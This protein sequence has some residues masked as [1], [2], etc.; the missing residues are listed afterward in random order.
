MVNRY[1]DKNGDER[2]KFI[3][4]RFIDSMKFIVSSL[5]SLMNNLVEGPRGAP[6]HRGGRKL[7]GFE[8]Y[9]KEQYELLVRKGIYPYEC[10]SCWDK[11]MESQLPP[12]ELA[13]SNVSN[14][15]YKHAQLIWNT[16]NILNLGEYHDLYH[17]TDVI[18]LANVFEAFR[19][20]CL[21][22]Y[23]LYPAHFYSS[24][25]LAWKACLKKTEVKLELLTDPDMLL[26]FEHGI[27]GD[28]T[29]AVH[30]YAT[31]NNPYISD[32][33]NPDEST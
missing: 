33:Y 9:S 22:H 29:Q 24:P 5:D 6:L 19:D 16:F 21:E 25:G 2:D 23:G 14:D 17:R 20:T 8:D 13:M 30:Q 28:I 3:D 26:M 31:V 32:R 4:L 15:D 27:R 1:T 11:F 7:I 10:M 12:I 18:L